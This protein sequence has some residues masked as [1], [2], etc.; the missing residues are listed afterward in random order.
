MVRSAAERQASRRIKL[1]A[2]K[3]ELKLF[4]EHEQYLALKSLC[5]ETGK[6]QAE[7]IG[8]LVIQGWDKYL[9]EQSEQQEEQL[10]LDV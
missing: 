7:V 5:Q 10:R 2:T 1:L 3:K 4:I 6:T 9:T 8:E